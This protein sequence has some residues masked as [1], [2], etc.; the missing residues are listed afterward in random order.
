MFIVKNKNGIVDFLKVN[1]YENNAI[2]L[3]GEAEGKNKIN[4]LA[5]FIFKNPQASPSV[6]MS[7]KKVEAIQFLGTVQSNW[8][9]LKSF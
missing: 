3:F 4:N 5:S 2:A 7:R 9:V 1:G 8:I 6:C